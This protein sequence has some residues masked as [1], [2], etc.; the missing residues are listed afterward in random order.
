MLFYLMFKA[1][2]VGRV[3]S[4]LPSQHTCRWIWTTCSTKVDAEVGWIKYVMGKQFHNLCLQVCVCVAFC[5]G[6]MK[7]PQFTAAPCVTT[8]AHLS[9]QET[10]SL[11]VRRQN[12]SSTRSLNSKGQCRRGGR[13][14]KTTSLYRR[15]IFEAV[16]AEGTWIMYSRH[17]FCSTF[18]AI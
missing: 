8:C 6:S 1:S 11:G 13:T 18:T 7:G 3:T 17:F 9:H 15:R 14:V 10:T 12:V 2:L 4:F 16:C 5:D